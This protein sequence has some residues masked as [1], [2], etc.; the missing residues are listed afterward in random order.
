MTIS[1]GNW[2]VAG[3]TCGTHEAPARLEGFENPPQ[4][5]RKQGPI[6]G[7]SFLPGP[8]PDVA[9]PDCPSE[10]ERWSREG[11]ERVE[12]FLAQDRTN[13]RRRTPARAAAAAK[14]S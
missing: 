8:A 3:T 4:M 11:G 13:Q 9:F 12:V 7:G 1:S 2:G 5:G 6:R 10:L 14:I